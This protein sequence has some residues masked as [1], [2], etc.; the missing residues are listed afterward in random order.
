[1]GD[2]CIN[3]SETIVEKL[4][5]IDYL[6]L[7]R[8]DRHGPISCSNDPTIDRAAP[9]MSMQTG[10]TEV[11]HESLQ[12]PLRLLD[13]AYM[14]ERSDGESLLASGPTTIYM[15]DMLNRCAMFGLGQ[16][17]APEIQSF[18]DFWPMP[19]MDSYT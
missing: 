16:I 4:T 5:D 10:D 15:D 18:P 3:Q 1:M 6:I 14:P 13:T 7:R 9:S 19:Y 17:I 11:P 2:I 8:K 12:S